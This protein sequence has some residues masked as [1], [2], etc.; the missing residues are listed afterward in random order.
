MSAIKYTLDQARTRHAGYLETKGLPTAWWPLPGGNDCLAYQLYILGLRSRTDLAPHYISISAFRSWAK[1][2]EAPIVSG[3]AGDLVLENWTGET[4]DGEL[5][6]EHIEY[7]YSIDHHAKTVTTISANTGPNP[8]VPSPRGVWKKTRPLDA[9]FLRVIRPP[10]SEPAVSKSRLGDVKA[11]ATYLNGLHLG[12]TSTAAQDGVE[13]PN[14]WW[15][16]QTWGRKNGVY[17]KAYVIDGIP[18]PHTRAV[19]AMILKL[20]KR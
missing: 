17:G 8:G 14:Y 20:A 5:V 13:G 1:W 15:M 6:P 4:D 12:R 19:E 9:H 3:K 7:I 10:Y 18:G 2:T 11:V 16:I